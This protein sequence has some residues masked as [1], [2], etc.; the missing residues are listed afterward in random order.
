MQGTAKELL[1]H[2]RDTIKL[3]LSSSELS[4]DDKKLVALTYQSAEKHAVAG[5]QVQ[6][7]NMV[8]RATNF[9]R[10]DA[11]VKKAIKIEAAENYL[12]TVLGIL[13][14]A[15]LGFL[16]KF[17]SPLVDDVADLAGDALADIL[18]S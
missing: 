7:D 12:S 10:S 1:G 6:A 15:G 8:R 14:A 17:G 11:L 5:R 16:N 9:V 2:G 3:L 4:A 13:S 18:G